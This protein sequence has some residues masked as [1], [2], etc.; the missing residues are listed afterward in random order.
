MIF[1]KLLLLFLAFYSVWANGQNT[2]GLPGII[3]YTKQAYKGGAQNWEIEQDATGIM[4]FANNEGLLSFD[5]SRWKIYPLPNRTNVRSVT[6][7]PDK[8]IYVGGQG[9]IGFFTPGKDGDLHYVSLIAS[10]KEN[11]RSFDDVWDIE[12]YE[13]FVFFRTNSKIF[14][15]NKNEIVAYPGRD[16]EF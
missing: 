9:E 4:Y 12:C 3:N 5:G 8:K 7:A 6:I 2:I 1:R 15:L 14:Q 10:I 16:W 11:D 13:G